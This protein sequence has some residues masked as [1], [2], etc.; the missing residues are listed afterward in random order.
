[1]L[2]RFGLRPWWPLESQGFVFRASGWGECGNKPKRT[3][4]RF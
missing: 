2:M 1:M 4:G 3:S